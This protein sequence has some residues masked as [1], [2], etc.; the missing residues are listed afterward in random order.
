[1]KVAV[2]AVFVVAL[3]AALVV[4]LRQH[5]RR[6]AEDGRS[7]ARGQ[8]DRGNDQKVTPSV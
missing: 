2:L 1:M 7:Q 3:V 8:I 5:S 6:T 4:P